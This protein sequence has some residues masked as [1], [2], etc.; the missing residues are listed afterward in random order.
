M[1]TVP[2][3]TARALPYVDDMLPPGIARQVQAE[4]D[5]RV[6]ALEVLLAESRQDADRNAEHCDRS[7]TT[8][9]AL[10]AELAAARRVV[11][12]A[13]DLVAIWDACGYSDYLAREL[14]PAG[15]LV[16]TVRDGR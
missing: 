1:T 13:R 14:G 4:H 5:A 2:T 3:T 9:Q 12:A 8:I 6:G 16:R 15:H 11:T 7:V 10:S